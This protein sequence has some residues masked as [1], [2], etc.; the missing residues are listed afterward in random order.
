MPTERSLQWS[1]TEP[2]AVSGPSQPDSTPQRKRFG[3]ARMEE[4]SAGEARPGG[5]CAERGERELAMGRASGHTASAAAAV[6]AGGSRGT[7]FRAAPARPLVHT[8]LPAPPGERSGPAA[9]VRMREELLQLRERQLPIVAVRQSASTSTSVSEAERRAAAAAPERDREAELASR[10]ADLERQLQRQATEIESLNARLQQIQGLR[11]SDS[12]SS[13]SPAPPRSKQQP[14]PPTPNDERSAK[15]QRTAGPDT[16][17]ACPFDVLPDELVKRI[18]EQLGMHAAYRGCV[19]DVCRRFRRVLALIEWPALVVSLHIA[20]GLRPIY[21]DESDDSEDRYRDRKSEAEVL[22]ETWRKL[23][24]GG[25]ARLKEGGKVTVYINFPKYLNRDEYFPDEAFRECK[26]VGA[27]LP[28]FFSAAARKSPGGLGTACIS[29]HGDTTMFF[30]YRS[31]ARFKM[32]ELLCNVALG[33]GTSGGARCLKFR[34]SVDEVLKETAARRATSDVLQRSLQPLSST[35]R[36]LELP[37]DFFLLSDD[38]RAIV[39]S[40]PGLQ[41]LDVVLGEDDAGGSGAANAIGQLSSLQNLTLGLQNPT[42]DSATDVLQG[43]ARG[44]AAQSLKTLLVAYLGALTPDAMEWIARMH[45]LTGLSITVNRR[46]ARSLRKISALR[47]LEYLGLFLGLPEAPEEGYTES[48]ASRAM[49]H[50]KEMCE[51]VADALRPLV[52]KQR[53]EGQTPSQGIQTMRLWVCQEDHHLRDGAR[54]SPF[55]SVAF[56]DLVSSISTVLT[57]VEYETFVL[58]APSTRELEALAACPRLEIMEFRHRAQHATDVQ[59]YSSIKHVEEVDDCAP[60][61]ASSSVSGDRA[62]SL[63]GDCTLS[64]HVAVPPR[65]RSAKEV[66]QSL[67]Q[68]WLPSNTD[69]E[70]DVFCYDHN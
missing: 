40:L 26:E 41:K 5:A 51:D 15:R 67:L 31:D 11:S 29:L 18:F 69:N 44:V 59:V 54:V 42:R 35:L 56:A 30:V 33:L 25:R 3:E 66:I 46:S 55:D 8:A 70:I 52:R 65:H 28:A 20:K 63:P 62:I 34:S 39:A 50:T 45:G 37:S 61:A 1:T 4:A 68:T 23:L 27:Q 43:I 14:Q 22:V 9:H 7:V 60:P 12:S 48:E 38:A 17:P 47:S 24:L 6:H 16:A 2:A 32:D 13:T 19:D 58:D 36:E 21:D 10:V 49:R 64:V 57:Y 53:A